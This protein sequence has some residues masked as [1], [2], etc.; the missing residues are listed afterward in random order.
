MHRGVAL[1]EVQEQAPEHLVHVVSEAVLGLHCSEELHCRQQA[2]QELS[3]FSDSS[4]RCH[5]PVKPC[6]L[7]F[8]EQLS[9]RR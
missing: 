3:D 1:A 7:Y 4:R 6:M 2:H 8:E 5:Y 9:L